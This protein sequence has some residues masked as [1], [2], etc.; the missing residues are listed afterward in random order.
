MKTQEGTVMLSTPSLHLYLPPYLTFFPSSLYLY[1]SSLPLFSLPIFTIFLIHLLPYSSSRLSHS[2]LLLY[3]NPKLCL[4]LIL[5]LIFTLIS[6]TLYLPHIPML[7]LLF[8]SHIFSPITSLPPSPPLFLLSL[9]FSL[10]LH[11]PPFLLQ[12]STVSYISTS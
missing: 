2:L 5:A 7:L 8:S 4:P 11:P 6:L 12:S 10:L 9:A 1:I 3:P